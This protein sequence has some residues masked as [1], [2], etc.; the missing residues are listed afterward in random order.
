MIALWRHSTVY[1]IYPQDMHMIWFCVVFLWFYYQWWVIHAKQLPVFFRVA[2]FH[3]YGDVTMGTMASQIT[4]L[5]IVYST[6]NS[7]ADKIKH[8]SSASLAFVRIYQ[9][10][11]NIPHKGPVT[12]K[13]FPFDDV[14]MGPDVVYR[15]HGSIMIKAFPCHDVIIAHILTHLLLD[16]MAT[17]SQTIFSDSF[18]WMQNFMF[19]LKLQW[20][21]FL[22]VQLAIRQHWFR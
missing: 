12:R 3:H 13:L 7:S 16:K 19:W 8:Q 17:F 18:L 21:L 22:R 9:W 5:A 4:S 15:P 2:L 11:V 6:V 1:G 10:P 20:S 14:I